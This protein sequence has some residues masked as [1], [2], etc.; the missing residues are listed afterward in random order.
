M[1]DQ[2]P[3]KGLDFESRIER[4]KNLLA[5]HGFSFDTWKAYYEL[6][7]RGIITYDFM[8]A[9]LI[10]YHP[11]LTNFEIA[12]AHTEFMAASSAMNPPPMRSRSEYL[13]M[14]RAIRVIGAGT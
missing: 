4:F 11:M 12:D 13:R 3:P 10:H 7:K 2:A 14:L 5:D 9:G 6:Y 1:S 8:V